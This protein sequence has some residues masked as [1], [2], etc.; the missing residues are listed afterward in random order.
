MVKE[1][2][3]IY[4]IL[5]NLPF[6]VLASSGADLA[7]TAPSMEQNVTNADLKMKLKKYK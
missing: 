3:V 5:T 7:V 1:D 6:R 2:K 4:L